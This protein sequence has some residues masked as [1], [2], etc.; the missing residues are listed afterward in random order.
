MAA[1]EAGA[2]VRL[3]DKTLYFATDPVAVDH[4]RSWPDPTPGASRPGCAPIASAPPDSDSTFVRMQ[5]EHI[6]IAGKL[7]LG[8]ERQSKIDLRSLKLA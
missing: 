7:G 4:D 2:E 1:R 5:P 6:E 8:R 3:G